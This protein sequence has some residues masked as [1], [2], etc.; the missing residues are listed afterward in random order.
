MK[1]KD[2]DRAGSQ[3]SGPETE[4]HPQPTKGAQGGRPAANSLQ[5][6]RILVPT[7]FSECSLQALDY[8]LGLANEFGAKITLLHIVEPA[9]VPD[10]Y[11][12]SLPTMDEVNQNVLEGG[13]ERLEALNRK[14]IG[15]RVPAETL[16]RMGRAHSEI[17]DTAK[18]LGIDLIVMGTHGA[19]GLQHI[20]L[21]STAERVIR[22]APCP[23]MTVRCSAAARGEQK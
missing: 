16:V 1:S 8:A 6:K 10:S 20:L 7:D 18:A 21:G 14:R 12:G 3:S 23:V 5:L 22:H 9:F 15:H 13:R 4:E 11:L 19:S 2:A 17:P